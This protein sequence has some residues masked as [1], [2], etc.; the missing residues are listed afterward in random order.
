[1]TVRLWIASDAPDTDFAAKLIDLHPPNDDY[2]QG[3]AM[4]LTEGIL[5]ALSR[6]LGRAV[7]AGA[8]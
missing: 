4:N 6:Q 1:M 8:A 7:A 2:P 3:F 5:R